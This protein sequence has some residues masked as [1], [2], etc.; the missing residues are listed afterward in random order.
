VTIEARI[1]DGAVGVNLQ[2]DFDV[3]TT[4]GIVVCEV[5]VVRVE[6]P[7]IGGVFVVF[8][9]N[10]AVEVVHR[11]SNVIAREVEARNTE[12]P[13]KQSQVSRIQEM[14]HLHCTKRSAVQVSGFALAMTFI[15]QTF[16]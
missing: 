16:P 8:D 12:N 11:F 3:V 10:F 6:M 4:Q 1:F 7:A 14:A 5:D 9:D 13:T 2:G 15:T